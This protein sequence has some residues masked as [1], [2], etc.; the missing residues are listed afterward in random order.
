MVP[1]AANGELF[2]VEPLPDGFVRIQSPHPRLTVNDKPLDVDRRLKVDIRERI[3]VRLGPREF[4]IIGVF[5][6][7]RP[8]ER[9]DDV[10]DAE[11]LQH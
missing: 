5:G 1:G 8:F 3:R 7:P 2:R 11:A 9:A 6:R 4:D 10:F